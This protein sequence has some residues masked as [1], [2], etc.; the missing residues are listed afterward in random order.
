MQPSGLVLVEQTKHSKRLPKGLDSLVR[1]VLVL[2]G[3]GRI[4]REWSSQRETRRA[5]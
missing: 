5:D 3:E 1:I 4:E 2:L